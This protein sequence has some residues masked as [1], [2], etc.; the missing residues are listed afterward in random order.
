MIIK[1]F[2]WVKG[3]ALCGPSMATTRE[4]EAVSRPA[5]NTPARKMAAM[6]WS[7]G[8]IRTYSGS[9]LTRGHRM[10]RPRAPDP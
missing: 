5:R 10:M 9:Y 1:L 8:D 6:T 2:T 4:L 7:V 3:G